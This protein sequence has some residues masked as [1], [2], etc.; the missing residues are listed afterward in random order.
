[1]TLSKRSYTQEGRVAVSS[2]RQQQLLWNLL[3]QRIAGEEHPLRRAAALS[4]TYVARSAAC[5]G[6]CRMAHPRSGSGGKAGATALDWR[7]AA[8]GAVNLLALGHGYGKTG[9]R[10][11]RWQRQMLPVWHVVGSSKW[12]RKRTRQIDFG[13]INN[14]PVVPSPSPDDLRDVRGSFSARTATGS[15]NLHPA[16]HLNTSVMMHLVQ[17]R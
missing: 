8:G 12:P 13:G 16:L 5:H 14:C 6:T 2:T 1:M 11:R 7:K 15:S 4:A 3:A 17:L 10:R 9:L